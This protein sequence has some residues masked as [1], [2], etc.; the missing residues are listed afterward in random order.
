MKTKAALE[1]SESYLK[2]AVSY[3]AIALKKGSFWFFAKKI[4]GLSDDQVARLVTE[5]LK[6]QKVKV[7]YVL[8]SVP[9]NQVTVRNLVLP[10]QNQE[11][12]LQMVD[13]NISRIVPYRKDEIAFGYYVLG[14]DEIGYTKVIVGIAPIAGLRKQSAM[15]EKT[16]LFIENFVLSSFGSWHRTAELCRNEIKNEIYI[17]LD[18]DSNC[19]DFII[20]NREGLLFSRT[21]SSSVAEDASAHE[22]VKLIGEI[23]QSLVI[24]QNEEMSKKPAK[25]FLA[26]APAVLQFEKT[27][28]EELSLPVIV[29]PA[30]VS[31]EHKDADAGGG[32]PVSVSFNAVA[33]LLSETPSK[34]LTFGIPEVQIRQAFK[35]K[36]RELTILGT[37]GIY[38]LCIFFLFFLSRI[39][40]Y[41][42]YLNKLNQNIKE[43]QQ[44]TGGLIEQE[45]KIEFVEDIINRRS[46]LAVFISQLYKITPAE[47]AFSYI[48]LDK[49][50]LATLRGQSV[51]LSDVFKFITKLENSPYFKDVDTKYTRTKK[52]KEKEVTDFEVSFATQVSPQ[53]QKK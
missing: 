39:Y 40:S 20:F 8:V 30:V 7:K 22:M 4:S 52:L 43:L 3:P 48:N 12:I 26:G 44:A 50:G 13:L 2:I 19:A 31:N 34:M 18:V 37:M 6:I 49:S 9:R 46:F 1:I 15:L 27:I 42:A 32:L 11:E 41:G 29:V 45:R 47:I 16:K 24:F 35:E 5:T 38:F 53:P 36:T 10:S 51:Q 33:S 17:L 25:I 21:I 23:K 28:S 14:R